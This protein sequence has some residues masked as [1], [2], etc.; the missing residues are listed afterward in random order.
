VRERE[1][2]TVTFEWEI[3]IWCAPPIFWS[4]PCIVKREEERGGGGEGWINLPLILA[5]LP[6]LLEGAFVVLAGTNL[7]NPVHSI[8][9]TSGSIVIVIRTVQLDALIVSLYFLL[10]S[11]KYFSEL[12]FW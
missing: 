12:K 11:S 7:G 8:P 4:A 6:V 3:F 5:R 10:G 2:R 9:Y 1:I